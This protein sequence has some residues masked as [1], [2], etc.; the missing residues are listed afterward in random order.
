MVTETPWF[1]PIFERYESNLKEM[2]ATYGH[3]IGLQVFTPLMETCEAMLNAGG[4][5]YV[6]QA[7]GNYFIGLDYPKD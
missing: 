5:T 6:K 3:W 7:D 1:K 2:K 4:M